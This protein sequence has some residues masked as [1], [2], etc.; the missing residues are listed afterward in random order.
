MACQQQRVPPVFLCPPFPLQKLTWP[1]TTGASRLGRHLHSQALS[2]AGGDFIP[3][4]LLVKEHCGSSILL[5]PQ[6]LCV[7]FLTAGKGEIT[8]PGHS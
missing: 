1:L 8:G 7:E 3:K 2:H 4:V 5:G 6:G